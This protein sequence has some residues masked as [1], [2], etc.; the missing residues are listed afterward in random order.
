[1]G[2]RCN[3]RRQVIAEAW[4]ARAQ[5]DVAD[6]VS[7]ATKFVAKSIAEDVVSVM[8]SRIVGSRLNLQGRRRR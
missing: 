4:R 6:K 3:E 5:A 8:R 1:M 2:C 7:E